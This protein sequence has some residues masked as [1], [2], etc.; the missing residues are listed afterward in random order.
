MP[1]SNGQLLIIH[2]LT[3]INSSGNVYVEERANKRMQAFSP[4]E[5]LHFN[6]RDQICFYF[7]RR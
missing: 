2:Y 3:S 6:N 4:C 7:S 5:C 1:L